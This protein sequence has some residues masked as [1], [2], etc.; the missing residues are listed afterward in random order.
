MQSQLMFEQKINE[1][2]KKNAVSN[3][4]RQKGNYHA[5]NKTILYTIKTSV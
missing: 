4:P 5:T 1:N 2:L 3:I